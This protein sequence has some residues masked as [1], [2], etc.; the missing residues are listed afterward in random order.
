MAKRKDPRNKGIT[1][2]DSGTVH[3]WN[4]R[5]FKNGK[6]YPK[7]FSDLKCGGKRK[8]QKEARQYRDELHEKLAQCPAEVQAVLKD[9]NQ[10][11]W[12]HDAPDKPDKM[13]V[14]APGI[15]PARWELK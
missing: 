3:G 2:I 12:A 5:G 14:D 7:L 10:R 11:I 13:P 1:R 9:R 15:D 4:V 6:T 8:A